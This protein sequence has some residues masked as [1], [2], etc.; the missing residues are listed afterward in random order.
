M[1]LLL[2]FIDG[3]G[4]GAATDSNP[5]VTAEMPFIRSLFSGNPLVKETVGEGIQTADWL[6]L[7]TDTIM[8][9]AGIPQSATGQTAFLSGINAARITGRH[10]H[11]FPTRALREILEQH[12]LFKVM[13]DNGRRAVFANTFT[14]EYFDT[15]KKGKWRHSATTTA[16][17]AGGCRLLMIPE[18]LRGAAVYQDI[19][20]EMLREKGYAVPLYEPEEA[21][22]HLLGLAQQQDFTLFEY[23]QT[24]R[25]GHAQDRDWADLIL[26]RLDRFLGTII[27]GRDK[28][29]SVLV[30]SDHGNLEDLSI[31]SHTFNPV[32]TLV[33]AENLLP[34]RS[35]L[36]LTDIYD[37]V[38]ETMGISIINEAF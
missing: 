26:N 10:I 20:N 2:V 4:L 23:F 30:V 34:F 33:F 29:L 18:L 7:P 32:P 9:V 19:T 37:S 25:C 24:D 17:L 11:G 22:R 6:L 13:N 35:I 28:T 3:F 1:P 27:A 14:E 31:K 36:T 16:A 12:S 15:V 8:G 21:A 5:F 38:L